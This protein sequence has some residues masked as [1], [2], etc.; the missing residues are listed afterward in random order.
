[1]TKYVMLSN[2]TLQQLQLVLIKFVLDMYTLRC[3]N[4][5]PELTVDLL[6]F[7]RST[8]N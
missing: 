6:V 5:W 4:G 7:R 8:K 3:R 2:V 1:M